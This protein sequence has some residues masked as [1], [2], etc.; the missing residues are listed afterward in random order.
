[1]SEIGIYLRE[2]FEEVVEPVDIDQLVAD[3]EVGE[4]VVVPLSSGWRDRRRGW[5]AAVVAAV[6]VLLVVGGVMVL[7]VLLGGDRGSVADD[8]K[9]EMVVPPGG[10]LPP[11]RADVVYEVPVGIP[12]ELGG[13]LGRITAHVEGTYAGGDGGF[14]LEVHDSSV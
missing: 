5:A 10:A 7:T 11:F 6:I 4:H 2:R 13:G 9:I 12:S 8:L 1:M 14:R 3:L